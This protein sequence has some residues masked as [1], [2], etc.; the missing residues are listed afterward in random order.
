VG[1]AGQRERERQRVRGKEWRRQLGPTE[2]EGVS[3]LGLAPTG[4]ARLS[5]T[6]CA[7]NTLNLG[8]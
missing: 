2:S 1:T 6:D 5:G 7:C 4:G 8:V 3:A